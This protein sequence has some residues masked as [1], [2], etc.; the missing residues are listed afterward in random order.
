MKNFDFFSTLRQYAINDNFSNAISYY[1]KVID[2]L[3][4]SKTT[5]KTYVQDQKLLIDIYEDKAKIEQTKGNC[6]NS[7]DLI[8]DAINIAEQM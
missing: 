8:K 7:V 1:D 6:D 4:A 3:K 5:D 2:T